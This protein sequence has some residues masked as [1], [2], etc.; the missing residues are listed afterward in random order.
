[1]TMT[2]NTV[3][4]FYAAVAEQLGYD[5]LSPTYV[6]HRDPIYPVPAW[7]RSAFTMHLIHQHGVRPST[8]N[9]IASLDVMHLHAHVEEAFEVR[10]DHRSPRRK[11]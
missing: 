11:P 2:D 3:P 1:M 9:T 4:M 8:K 5:P 10:H 6:P 7:N